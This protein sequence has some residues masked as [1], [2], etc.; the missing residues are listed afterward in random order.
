MRIRPRRGHV[1][2]REPAVLVPCRQRPP[3]RTRHHARGLVGLSAHHRRH[4]AVAGEAPRRLGVHRHLRPLH[5]R[6]RRARLPGQGRHLHVDHDMRLLHASS[7]QVEERVSSSLRR[8]PVVAVGR[9]PEHRHQ[10]RLQGRA[11]VGSELAVEHEHPAEGLVEVQEPPLVFLVRLVQH[12]IRLQA[13]PE[14]HG[15]HAEPR[16]I[17]FS[18]RRHQDRFAVRRPELAQLLR[19]ASDQSR[20]LLGDLTLRQRR[21][22]ER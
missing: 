21:R 16:R 19:G 12:S 18:G 6:R 9:R 5:L 22:C 20:V 11:V 10:R 13:V 1:A 2:P 17:G 7:D 14:H 15:G 3:H 4:R 8:R